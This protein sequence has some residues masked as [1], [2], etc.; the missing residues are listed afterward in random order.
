MLCNQGLSET[1]GGSRTTSHGVVVGPQYIGIVAGTAGQAV[2]ASTTV[3]R[4]VA[5]IAGQQV[6]EAI[7]VPAGAGIALKTNVESQLS[8]THT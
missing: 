6:V 1:V 8:T 2:D 3:Q 7:A 5:R 4:I